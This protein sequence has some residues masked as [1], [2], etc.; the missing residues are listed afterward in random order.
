MKT[1]LYIAFIV[2]TS[3]LMGCTNELDSPIP[4]EGTGRI[5]LQVSSDSKMQT[6]G[7]QKELTEEQKNQ[8]TVCIYRG[9]TLLVS[10]I[11]SQ[12]TEEDL[13]VQTGSGY[14]V[15]AES[16]SLEE[17][18]DGFGQ[19]R[20]FG[21][22]PSLEVTKGQTSKASVHCTPANAG[23]NVVTT[24]NFN[25]IFSSYEMKVSH[26]GRELTFTPQNANT[27][28]Y[29]NV[30]ADGATLTYSLKATPTAGGNPVTA[31]S[32]IRLQVGKISQLKL[33]TT[34]KGT[35][36]LGITYDDEFHTE[37]IDINIDTEENDGDDITMDPT[38]ETNTQLVKARK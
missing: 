10:K 5:A 23:V 2:A 32:T 12:L 15:T 16:C 22:S 37:H 11:F 31:S 6:R 28:G 27:T 29:Y 18:E 7:E 34:A 21:T 36:T 26:G 19:I 3:L 30:P 1:Y 33:D 13:T 14:K 17:A 25:A 35:I 4:M 24:E 8:F 38:Q 20:L 9:S